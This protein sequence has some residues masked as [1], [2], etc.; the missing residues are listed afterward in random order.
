MKTN[1]P[2]VVQKLYGTLI[3]E[4]HKDI[5]QGRIRNATVMEYHKE[6]KFWRNA[7]PL[8]YSGFIYRLK[9]AWL[10][11]MEKADIVIWND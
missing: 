2:K 11:F 8:G 3:Y 5:S 7:R 9:C 4:G 10:V 1:I 6:E